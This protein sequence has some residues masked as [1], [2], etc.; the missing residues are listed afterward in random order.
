MSRQ[1][2]NV[3]SSENLTHYGNRYFKVKTDGKDYK[4]QCNMI[5]IIVST[6]RINVLIID[7]FL[8]N[9]NVLL[10]SF[11]HISIIISLKLSHKDKRSKTYYT[12]ILAV[13]I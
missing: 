8:N 11:S 7:L 1:V 10:R 5:K 12:R 13:P 6:R 9:P 4:S 3:I 2:T